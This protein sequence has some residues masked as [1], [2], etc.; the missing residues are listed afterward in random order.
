M[1]GTIGAR[2][3]IPNPALRRLG[4]L[5]GDWRTAGTHPAFPD[6]PLHGRT[7]FA[8]HEGG[9]F[10][11]MRSEVDHP[12]FPDGVAIIGSDDSGKFAMTYFDERGVSRLLDVVVGDGAVTWRHD[13][14]EFA[15]TLT[16]TAED[17]G[18]RLVSQ[19]RMSRKSA[20]WED[21]LS[22]VFLR[23]EA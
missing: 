18:K 19:G 2:A 10:L 14:P 5:V 7:C 11:V 15:Q 12:Q 9:A 21:D 6:Q 16:I 17:S 3:L 20:P 1:S 13:D 23:D 22:Q 8:W 4:F